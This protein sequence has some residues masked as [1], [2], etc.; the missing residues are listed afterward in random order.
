MDLRI[1]R[2]YEMRTNF[3]NHTFKQM[4]DLI[5]SYAHVVDPVLHDKFY[6]SFLFI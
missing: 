6:D 5:H 2:S 4:N 3:E 1:D